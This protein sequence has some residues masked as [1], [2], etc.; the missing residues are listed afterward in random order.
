MKPTELHEAFT[1]ARRNLILDHP[2]FGSLCMYL[3]PVPDESAEKGLW[4]DGE[5]LGYNPAALEAME[6]DEAAGLI[7]K[8][9]LHCV[10]EHHLRRGQR[11]QKLW[12][13]VCDL[14]TNPHILCSPGLTLPKAATKDTQYQEMSA[15]EV[16][17]ILELEQQ[18]QDQQQ[19]GKGQG[20]GS[21]KGKGKQQPQPQAGSGASGGQGQG[22]GQPT[23]EVRDL[24]GQQPGQAPS[25]AQRNQQ[26]QEWKTNAK[27]AAQNAK[28]R[29]NLPGSLQRLVDQ[30]LLPLVD[31][32][33]EMRRFM[34]ALAKNDTSFSRPNR[35]FIGRGLYLPG[36]V[37]KKMG[38][39]V[40]VNDTSGST[41]FA[42]ERFMS[43][44]GNIIEDVPF[45]RIIY[46]QQDATI[47]KI[48][49]IEPGDELDTT[50]EGG[51]GTDFRPV[52]AWLEKEEIVPACMVFLT[53]L[54]GPFP[55]TEPEF[56]VLWAFA[57]EHRMTDEKVPFGEIIPVELAREQR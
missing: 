24:P 22:Q 4:V 25:E 32:R 21:G 35:R 2:F 43:E 37:S 46:V 11:D 53:D 54:D 34:Q 33:A 50:M 5:R 8:G 1:R 27:Q 57:T 9:V 51:G 15:E 14:V 29:G 49:E 36:Q 20:G 18:K 6:L 16:Y 10:F 45:E 13:Q 40:L 55:K 12:Q 28:A 47:Q 38:T 26:G 39:L 19:Q 3:T 42:Q 7:A 56:P 52:F 48:T 44:M 23:G 31:W 17:I 30:N 41:Q